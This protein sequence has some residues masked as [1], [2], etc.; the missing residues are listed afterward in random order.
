[1]IPQL[2]GKRFR[3][4]KYGLSSWEDE[5]SEVYMS[6]HF[7]NHPNWNG[8]QNIRKGIDNAKKLGWKPEFHIKAKSTGNDYLLNEI[9]IYG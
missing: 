6:Y 4:N 2:I 8:I 5:I 7:V 9:I 3:R 1:M